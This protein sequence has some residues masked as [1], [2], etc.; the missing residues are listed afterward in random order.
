MV[1]FDH[2]GSGLKFTGEKLNYFSISDDGKNFI[3]AQAKIVN[4]KVVV[5]NNLI[6]KPIAVRYAWA[7]SPDGANLYNEEGLPASSFKSN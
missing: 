6:S 3:P 2:V 5:W 1:S 4:N 7:D